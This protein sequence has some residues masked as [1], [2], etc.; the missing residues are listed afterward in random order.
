MKHLKLFENS[1]QNTFWLFD[2]YDGMEH[3]YLLFSNEE[4]CKNYIIETIND[5]RKDFEENYYNGYDDS[6]YFTDVDEAIE[7]S[8]DNNSDVVLSY[9]EVELHNYKMNNKLKKM[10]EIKKYNL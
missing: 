2:Y 5:E 8:S 7:W 4:D 10:K 9:D 3:S 1:N 6:M